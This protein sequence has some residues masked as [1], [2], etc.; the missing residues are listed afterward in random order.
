[1]KAFLTDVFHHGKAKFKLVQFNFSTLLIFEV[2]Y[3]LIG[4]LVVH[5]GCLFLFNKVMT[6]LGFP[7]LSDA[8]IGQALTNPLGLLSILV[9]ILVL[10][11]YGIFELTAL[12][13]LF[14]ESFFKRQV[15]LLP[16]CKKAFERAIRIV[17]PRNFPLIIFVLIIIPFTEFSLASSFVYEIKIPEYIMSH[18]FASPLLS[19]GYFVLLIA[20]FLIVMWGIF[21]IHYFTLEDQPFIPAIKKSRM[22][23]KGHFWHTT[24]WVA[25]WNI[26]ILLL[27]GILFGILEVV[28][29][30]ILG[31]LLHNTLAVSI[32]IG[33]FGFF[34]S[35]FF[36]AFQL[37]ETGITFS[38]VSIFYY[39][40]SQMARCKL[41]STPLIDPKIT[42]DQTAKAHKKR[43]I[44]LSIGAIFLIIAVDTYLIYTNFNETFN[45]HFA[46]S[47]KITAQSTPSASAPEN[48]LAALQSAINEGADYAQIN[49]AQSK[50]GVIVVAQQ[51][52][53]GAS[54]ESINIWETDAAALKNVGVLPLSEVIA[55][56]RD[57]IKLNI[58]LNPT[59]QETNLI[60]STILVINQ[61]N[62]RDSCILSAQNYPVLEQAA[63]V[64]PQIRRAYVTSVALGD[65]QT[66]PVDALSIEASFIGPKIVTAIH[67]EKKEVFAWTV[68]S[69]EAITEMIHLGVDNIITEDV[70]EVKEVIHQMTEPKALIKQINDF[71][72][73]DIE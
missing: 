50:D 1:M 29:F 33:F 66:L 13:V 15:R 47:P 64:D 21:S 56:C 11:F 28:S 43:F 37:I 54:G 17:R 44:G 20:S 69:E 55:F 60:E 49:V 59:G 41:S 65:I 26:A 8:N 52:I 42:P 16:L 23:I 71:L 27:L 46:E 45:S 3:T 10:G 36:T 34:V 63:G 4:T 67:G 35:V 30:F 73:K 68:N 53:T 70:S 9:L 2:L 31:Q 6:L 19:L 38:L 7:F 25:F 51:T 24:F 62:F 58:L 40:Y 12:I 48:T 32:F 39:D 22:L 61:T 14:N 18:I 5:P 57:K 72:F